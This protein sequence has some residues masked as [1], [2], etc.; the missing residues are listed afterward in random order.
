MCTVQECKGWMDKDSEEWV[1]DGYTVSKVCVCGVV[2]SDAGI[3]TQT[4]T[5]SLTR[6]QHKTDVMPRLDGLVDS[7]LQPELPDKG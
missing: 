6:K 5:H 7:G 1:Q 4:Q 2:G 3:L